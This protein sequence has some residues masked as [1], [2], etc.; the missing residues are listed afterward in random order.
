MRGGVQGTSEEIIILKCLSEFID[1][2]HCRH[3]RP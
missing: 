2:V 1:S 3:W